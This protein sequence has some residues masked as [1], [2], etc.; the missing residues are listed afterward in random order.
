MRK[1]L[2]LLV[3]SL[4]GAA[5]M[6]VF[7]YYALSD[8]GQLQDY[9]AYKTVAETSTDLA[10]LFK[11]NAGQMTQRINLFAD[12][13]WFLLSSIFTSIGLHGFLVSK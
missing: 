8:W 9:L 2:L 12:G 1:I 4:P 11:A 7:G 10:V 5:G 13:T 6:A 3:I